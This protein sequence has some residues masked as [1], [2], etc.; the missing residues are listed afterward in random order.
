MQELTDLQK[1]RILRGTAEEF[2][3]LTTPPSRPAIAKKGCCG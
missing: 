3:G 2:L 1:A